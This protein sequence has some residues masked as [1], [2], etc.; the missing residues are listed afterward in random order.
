MARRR[1]LFAIACILLAG[2]PS[3]SVRG[4]QLLEEVREAH[5]S[6]VE[7]MHTFSCKVSVIYPADPKSLKETG[8]YWRSSDAVRVRGRVGDI[9]FDSL[10]RDSVVRTVGGRPS[11]PGGARQHG[12]AITA[13]KGRPFPACDVWELALCLFPGPGTDFMMLPF[14][15][16]LKRS[17]RLNE[18]SRR[19]QEGKEYIVVAYTH[20]ETNWTN[21]F[22]IWFD[23]RVNCLAWKS[24]VKQSSAGSANFIN[25]TEQRVTSFR[26]VAPGVFFPDK[27]QQYDGNGKV[28]RSASISDIRV[29]EPLA[30]N[31]FDL[32]FPPGI[33]VKDLVQGKA[34]LT[35]ADGKP[36][37]MLEDVHLGQLPSP[38]GIRPIGAT[39]EEPKTWTSWILP[40]SIT[41]L[42]LAA[43]F[44]ALRRWRALRRTRVPG[45][46]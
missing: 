7:S 23:P 30:P 31:T 42:V 37:Q 10:Q 18:V 8:Q 27:V 3:S 33:Q 26:E 1:V 16:L 34:Y 20:R 19:V 40:I 29:N 11:G 17:H 45:L 14:D 15:E 5:R 43:G 46:P 35:G 39:R 13:A 21:D 12:A 4:Q 6:T 22:E 24:V 44:L 36:T 32:Q 9:E 38:T 25:T 2:A 28:L 41:S